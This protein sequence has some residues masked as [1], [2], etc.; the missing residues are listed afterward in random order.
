M[1]GV[2]G[3]RECVSLK[4]KREV[5][6]LEEVCGI[7]SNSISLSPGVTPFLP[8]EYSR[9]IADYFSTRNTN[10]VT[11]SNHWGHVKRF[12]PDPSI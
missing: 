2:V 6:A 5:E 4:A 1:E 10:T 11:G 12:R 7:K 9:A 8:C 3:D